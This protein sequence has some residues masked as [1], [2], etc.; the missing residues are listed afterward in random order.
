[1][2]S[3]ASGRFQEPLRHLLCSAHAPSQLAK[4]VLH[5]PLDVLSKKFL[6]AEKVQSVTVLQL[7]EIGQ[8]PGADADGAGALEHQH[9]DRSERRRL[10]EQAC[11][12]LDLMPRSA[13]LSRVPAQ[14]A[15]SA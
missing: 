5:G 4:A 15:F 11:C 12:C 7:Q 9:V 2:L 8:A 1:V 3:D 10:A 6:L 13:S 14:P